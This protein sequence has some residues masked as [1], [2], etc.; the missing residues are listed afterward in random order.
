MRARRALTLTVATAA[1]LIGTSAPAAA[2]TDYRTSTITY[3]CTFPGVGAQPV[4]AVAGFTGP[5]AVAS[6][7]AITAGFFS[8]GI[9]VSPDLYQLMAVSLGYDGVRGSGTLPITAVNAFPAAAN[10]G[11]VIPAVF[12]DSFNRAFY[13]SGTG[14]VTF[15]A[16]PP[17]AASFRLGTPFSLAIEFH[18]RQNGTWMPWTMACTL[19]VTT[20]GQYTYFSPSVPV[21]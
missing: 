13:F 16:G 5:D 1:V 19:R 6:G 8:G 9:A 10:A 4:T 2:A 20:P 18:R 17:G 21:S 14:P 7:E 11:V 3:N 12:W 15:T